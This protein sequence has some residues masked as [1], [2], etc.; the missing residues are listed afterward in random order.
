MDWAAAGLTEQPF[1]THGKPVAI[2]PYASHSEAYSAI[3][4][5]CEKPTGLALLQGPP[6]SGKSTVVR[7]LAENLDEDRA[8]AVVDGT[9]LN[10][11]GLLEGALRQFG[12]D[13]DFNL[14]SELLAMLRVF[15]L[16]QTASYESPVLIIE[17]THRLNP[18]ALRA[19]CELAAL[20]HRQT[21]ALKIVL[22]SDRSLDFI[23]DAPAMTIVA[24]RISADI[25]MRPMSCDEA[26]DYLRDKLRAAGSVL[27][28]YVFPNSVCVELWDASGGWPGV[29]DR[30]AL[31]AL[32]KAETL[33]V[34]VSAVERPAVPRATWDGDSITDLD[35]AVD[36]VPQPPQ[37]FVS[38]EGATIQELTFDK[39]RLLIGRSEHNDI[40]IPSKFVSRHHMLLVRH[41]S[42]TFLM[43]L[44]SSNGTFVNSRRVS[45]HILKHNDVITIGHHHIKFY[46]P[47]ATTRGPLD[48]TEFADTV[49]MKS[50]QDMRKLLAQENTA[51]LP[52]MTEDLPTYGNQ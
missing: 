29:L 20:K 44:N 31:L 14:T 33:P 15:A 48:G 40:A 21:S 16:Q 24:R 32:A 13:V 46:D 37:L 30:I 52:T 17:N 42:T 5:S 49:V 2:V 4:E 50:L 1:R 36:E 8:L 3:R 23:I 22:V 9:S 38:E 18:S 47:H 11:A 6:L 41:G 39:A 45:N 35:E 26:R 27:P 28:E 43:D 12:Y 10:T 7:R 34:T 51:I 25:H 19:L